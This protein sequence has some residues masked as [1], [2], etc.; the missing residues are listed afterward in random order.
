MA[1]RKQ[2][3]AKA[4]RLG[5]ELN[6]TRYEAELVSPKGILWDG[7]HYNIDYFEDGKQCTWDYFWDCMKS[8]R[9][10]DCGCGEVK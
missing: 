3:E 6:V 8:P 9:N 5:G 10:C 2:V 1:S 4:K 7:Y